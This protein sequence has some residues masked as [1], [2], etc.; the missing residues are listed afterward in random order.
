[1]CTRT[2]NIVCKIYREVWQFEFGHFEMDDV[3]EPLRDRAVLQYVGKQSC[4]Y[5]QFTAALSCSVMS[6]LSVTAYK[7]F[8]F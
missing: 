1:M 7:D 8:H 2:S 3:E 6:Q 4:E 5:G